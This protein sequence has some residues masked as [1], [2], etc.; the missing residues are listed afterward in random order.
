[1]A[2]TKAC[3]SIYLLLTG[4]SHVHTM[5]ILSINA[6]IVSYDVNMHNAEQVAAN[7][8]FSMNERTMFS[9]S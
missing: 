2:G 1:M 7:N 6:T 9:M 8:T 5:I 4:C 3:K